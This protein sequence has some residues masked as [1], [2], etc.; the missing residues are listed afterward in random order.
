MSSETIASATAAYNEFTYNV[1][2]CLEDPIYGCG[3]FGVF[4]VL[5]AGYVYPGLYAGGTDILQVSNSISGMGTND[6]NYYNY[7][8]SAGNTISLPGLNIG[9]SAQ[10]ENNGSLSDGGS[11]DSFVVTG[12]CSLGTEGN[13]APCIQFDWGISGSVSALSDYGSSCTNC[14]D[15]SSVTAS[16]YFI[17]NETQETAQASVGCVDV[18][19]GSETC[20]SN[21]YCKNYQSSPCSTSSN[22][23]PPVT[24]PGGLPCVQDGLSFSAGDTFSP[25]LTILSGQTVIWDGYASVTASSQDGT[26]CLNTM[27]CNPVET[28]QDVIVTQAGGGIS[29]NL[30]VTGIDGV[31]IEPSASQQASQEVAPTMQVNCNP[32]SVNPGSATSCNATLSGSKGAP[33]GTVTFSAPVDGGSFSPSGSCTLAS[34]STPDQ[35]Q[36]SVSYT[37]AGGTE[38][39][40]TIS[41][42]YSGDSN[43]TSDNANFELTVTSPP[44]STATSVNCADS[45]IQVGEPDQCTVQVTDTASG[46]PTTPTGSVTPSIDGPSG[47]YSSN[48]CVLSESGSCSFTFT[49]SN[50]C[51]FLLIPGCLSTVANY[52]GDSIH[53]PSQGLIS[54]VITPATTIALSCT[55]MPQVNLGGQGTIACTA[56]VSGSDIA[57][58]GGLAPVTGEVSFNFDGPVQPYQTESC[59]QASASI[60]VATETCTQNYT[61][62]DAG[63]VTFTATFLG[64]QYNYRTGQS[65]TQTVQ[66]VT[67]GATGPGTSSSSSCGCSDSG[68]FVPLSYLAL[69]TGQASGS[70]IIGPGG[71]STL[72]VSSP[73][74]SFPVTLTLTPAN[75]Q[76]S[77]VSIQIDGS[78]GPS[79]SY[80]WSAN[81]RYF[82][83]IQGGQ[84][85]DDCQDYCNAEVYIS[86]YDITTGK[87]LTGFD[88]TSFDVTGGAITWGFSPDADNTFFFVAE[89]GGQDAGTP[90]T[91]DVTIYNLATG[92][93][94]EV[95]PETTYVPAS[96]PYDVPLALSYATGKVA[97]TGFSFGFSPNGQTFNFALSQPDNGYELNTVYSATGDS[98]P[99]GPDGITYT[100]DAGAS[101]E[102]SPCGDYLLLVQPATS[103][104]TL[105]S[106]NG[107]AAIQGTINSGGPNPS[108]PGSADTTVVGTW[109]V[110]PDSPP[111][112]SYFGK[113]GN[114]LTNVMGRC[115]DRWAVRGRTG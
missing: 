70:K 42:S 35:S 96:S 109:N 46:T 24:C 9:V 92:T 79:F 17:T 15:T 57:A 62:E 16:F 11:W 36:C 33:T 7:T 47:T 113:G 86:I 66:I 18:A 103:A 10:S 29:T 75:S 41:G 82:V 98:V 19:S 21:I 112:P 39:I 56:V 49:P 55:P 61:P 22:S 88:L 51:H 95:V 65:N 14:Q 100:A 1:P 13:L 83:V 50:Y 71:L 68:P 74:T 80:G 53:S 78:L 58:P 25:Q 30:T 115:L 54:I 106:M 76:I 111:A 67:S 44:R 72:T 34:T 31:T 37:P 81:G 90:N 105:F 23:L 59:T 85:S 99:N 69:S 63:T 97:N 84:S 114:M 28:S 108:N 6:A 45:I 52:T 77:P 94:H 91:L 102:Y 27:D 12:T 110:A 43:Y 104:A 87:T 93:S 60:Y 3:S 8:Y 38:G 32:T 2:E 40:Q 5:N 64:D 107:N 20:S 101:W 73:P 26:P 48:P 89:M 4:S